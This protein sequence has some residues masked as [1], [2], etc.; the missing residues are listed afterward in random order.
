M[1]VLDLRGRGRGNVPGRGL[2]CLPTSPQLPATSQRGAVRGALCRAHGAAR[3]CLGLM[4]S[5]AAAAEG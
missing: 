4:A 5:E 1:S 3:R 2:Q